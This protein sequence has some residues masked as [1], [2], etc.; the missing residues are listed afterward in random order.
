MSLVEYAE[1]FRLRNTYVPEQ[2]Y[3][4]LAKF[5][6]MA[7][8]QKRMSDE[9]VCRPVRVC[10]TVTSPIPAPA[11]NPARPDEAL[12]VPEKIKVTLRRSVGDVWS[13]QPENLPGTKST[14]CPDGSSAS[15]VS[16]DAGPSTI[17]VSNNLG[18][19]LSGIRASF[20][21]ENVNVMSKQLLK[22]KG[23][24]NDTLND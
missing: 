12:P 15:R 5:E 22:Q 10:G 4:R 3:G 1:K 8:Q 11:A 17:S 23:E 19:F 7:E 2:F 20:R 18:S 14:P 6:N 13:A 21:S 16:P 24:N 9:A